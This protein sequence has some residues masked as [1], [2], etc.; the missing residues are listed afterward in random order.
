MA[1]TSYDE[2]SVGMRCH[3]EGG[4]GPMAFTSYDEVRP[5]APHDPTVAGVQEQHCPERR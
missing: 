1:F 4:L 2:V 3:V 5:W